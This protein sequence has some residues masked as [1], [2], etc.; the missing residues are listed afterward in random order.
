M[1]TEQ[2]LDKLRQ[3][4]KTNKT[5]DEIGEILHRNGYG[6]YMKLLRLGI[7]KAR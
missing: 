4:A 6:V 5:C 1:W 3:L 7:A 2:E